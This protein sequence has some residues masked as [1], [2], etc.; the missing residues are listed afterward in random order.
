M[1]RCPWAFVKCTIL[2]MTFTY[3][4]VNAS[5]SCKSIIL[6]MTSTTYLFHPSLGSS[7]CHNMD[8][9]H[10]RHGQLARLMKSYENMVIKK[11][12]YK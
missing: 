3:S 1:C 11:D 2:M 6:M 4:F 12:K 8:S 5:T 9:I 10:G 7:A